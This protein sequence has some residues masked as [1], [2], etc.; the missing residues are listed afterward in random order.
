MPPRKTADGATADLIDLL[1]DRAPKLRAAGVTSLR[2][3]DLELTLAPTDA[4]VATN[5]IGIDAAASDRKRDDGEDGGKDER[6]A[7]PGDPMHD[8]AT[9]AGGRVPGFKRPRPGE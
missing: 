9:Y 1:I 2:Y 4:P 5:A 8:P 6:P 7:R 3:A